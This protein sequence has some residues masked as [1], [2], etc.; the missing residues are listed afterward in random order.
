[1]DIPEDILSAK[2]YINMDMILNG[3]RT[4]DIWDVSNNIVTRKASTI[5][6]R[7]LDRRLD[8]LDHKELHK[9]TMYT[10]Q[11]TRLDS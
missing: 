6:R 5:I 10:L 7:V 2:L 11:L 4:R 8:L 9:I 1:M 3:Y